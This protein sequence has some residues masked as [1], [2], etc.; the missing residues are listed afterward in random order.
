MYVCPTGRKR[1]ERVL[2]EVEACDLAK[3]RKWKVTQVAELK[4]YIL[5]S[6]SLTFALVSNPYNLL[7]NTLW[8]LLS[9]AL[10]HSGSVAGRA[11]G[12][13]AGSFILPSA[14]CPAEHTHGMPSQKSSALDLRNSAGKALSRKQTQCTLD[15]KYV[16]EEGK[17]TN[18]TGAWLC[19]MIAVSLVPAAYMHIV[20][21]SSFP[22]KPYF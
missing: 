19:T 3:S 10:Q 17:T 21:E 11:G 5:L 16:Q 6:S 22:N 9:A 4:G 1:R 12:R 18:N 13:C 8:I 15:V 2:N 14:A 7:W 20:K